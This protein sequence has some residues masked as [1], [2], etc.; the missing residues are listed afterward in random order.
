MSHL[1][2]SALQ[3]NSL[4]NRSRSPSPTPRDPGWTD[5]YAPNEAGLPLYKARNSLSPQQP[6]EVIDSSTARRRGGG[7]VVDAFAQPGSY[8]DDEKRKLLEEDDG[9]KGDKSHWPTT[10]IGMEEQFNETVKPSGRKEFEAVGS[11]RKVKDSGKWDKLIPERRPAS[12]WVG[13]RARLG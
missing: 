3:S 12:S 8:E 5:P 6:M 2:S 1:S 13:R 4:N 11:S 7:P 9:G 10:G